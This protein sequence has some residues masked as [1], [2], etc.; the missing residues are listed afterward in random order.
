MSRAVDG[1]H[2]G[3]VGV[4]DMDRS[5]DF[6][7]GLLRFA[8]AERRGGSREGTAGERCLL[9]SGGRSLVLQGLGEQPGAPAWVN[10]DLQAGMRHIGLKVD[11]VDAWAERARDAGVRFTVEPEDAFGDVRLCFFLDPDG[12]HLEF[13]QG[14]VNY[15]QVWTPELVD[16]E[17]AVPV[18]GTPRFDHVAVSVR[19]LDATLAFYHDHLGFPVIAQLKEDGADRGFTI[20]FVQ[21]GPGVMEIF[22]FSEPLRANSFS[23]AARA[24][25]LLYLGM[26]ARDVRAAAAEL[27]AGGAWLV[28]AAEEEQPGTALAVDADGTP[29]EVVPI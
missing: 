4:T 14:N 15:N 22:S 3:V 24:P 1:L 23:P 16:R 13:V 21:A 6:Y 19:D 9:T 18:P 12:A 29:L 17:R 2:F 26:G 20:T 25:G 8:L 27:E 28:P 11:D 7:C 10:D 5:L